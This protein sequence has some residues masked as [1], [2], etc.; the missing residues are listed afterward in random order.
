[1]L[2]SLWAGARCAAAAQQLSSGWAAA[3]QPLGWCTLELELHQLIVI[4]VSARPCS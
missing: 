4:I 2:R 3:K 1:M